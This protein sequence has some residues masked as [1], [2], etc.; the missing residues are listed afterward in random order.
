M[1]L[2]PHQLTKLCKHFVPLLAASAALLLSQGQAKAILNVNIFD[3]GPNLKVTVQGSLSQL[4]T[5]GAGF[6]CS[7]NGLLL[8]QSA[9]GSALC[10]GPNIGGPSFSLSGPLGFGGNSNR[11]ANQVQ[12]Q[13]FFMVTQSYTN[14]TS[15]S[16]PP[17]HVID[18]TYSLNQPFFSSA[19]F[20]GR[21]LASE[22][23]TARGLFG[24][25]TIDGTSESIN[26]YIGPIP[27][28]SPLPLLGAGAAFGWS[29][30]LRKRIA[31]PMITPPQ[32]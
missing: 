21:S 19:T 20:N 10:T 31:T 29:R 28:P 32:A 1:K 9:A 2:A 7:Y 25:W 4:G 6:S 12:G 8:G 27:T 5:P 23:F 17:L 30:R 15:S 22:G 26:V 18:P 13:G 14:R 3:D 16:I 24:T 11:I